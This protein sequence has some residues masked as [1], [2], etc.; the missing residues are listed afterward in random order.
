MRCHTTTYERGRYAG[1]LTLDANATGY[2]PLKG[3]AGSAPACD[4]PHHAV[5]R[6]EEPNKESPMEHMK[7]VTVIAP[8]GTEVT[9]YALVCPAS[10]R[11]AAGSIQQPRYQKKHSI[12]ARHLAREAGQC[13]TRK[14]RR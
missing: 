12:G 7:Q 3:E 1:H 14:E 6:R 5:S 2:C 4:A 10:R 9:T 11:L 8:D 13:D